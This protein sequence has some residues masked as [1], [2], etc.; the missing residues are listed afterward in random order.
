MFESTGWTL[1]EPQIA[2]ESKFDVIIPTI[3]KP[4]PSPPS[5]GGESTNH[6]EIGIIRQ[7][8]FSSSLQR[9]SV[10]AKPLV[11]ACDDAGS[12]SGSSVSSGKSCMGAGSD[13]PDVQGF[14]LFCKGAPEKI[15]SLCLPHTGE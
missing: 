3:V 1:E 2:D 13:K 7:F 5:K 12:T 10:I 9:M 15:T 4:S 8:P 6:V 11:D 14:H